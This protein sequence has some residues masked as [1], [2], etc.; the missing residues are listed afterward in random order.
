LREFKHSA[1]D[2]FFGGKVIQKE[3]GVTRADASLPYTLMMLGYGAG[4]L[5]MGKLADKW[6]VHVPLWI[7]ALGVG[8]GFVLAGISSVRFK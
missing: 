7:S 2:T 8:S 1:R 5:A 3:F 4:G 6:G